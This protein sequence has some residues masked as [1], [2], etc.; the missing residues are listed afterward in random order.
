MAD[1]VRD[2]L[3]LAAR[4]L[5][6]PLVWRGVRSLTGRP[7]SDLFQYLAPQHLLDGWVAIDQAIA[8]YRF[9]GHWG[10][11]HIGRKPA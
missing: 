3:V 4:A 5:C 9:Q 6:P 8:D 10:V 7:S 1:R 2:S 11:V